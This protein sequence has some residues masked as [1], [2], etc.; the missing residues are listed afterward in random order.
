MSA[1]ER[2]K[3]IVA[4]VRELF[5]QRG[6]D[7]ATTRELARAA[8]VS[9]GLLFK[10]FPTKQ[11][12]YQAMLDS[13]A[14]ELPQDVHRTLDLPPSTQTLIAIVHSLA[15]M[16]LSRH[17]EEVDDVARMY[18]RSLAGDGVFAD[19]LLR[20]PYEDLIPRLEKSM[21]AA[22]VSGDIVD[23]P[24]PRRAR[25]WFTERLIFVLMAELLPRDRDLKF[26][27]SRDTI[28]RDATWFVLRGI[29]LSEEVIRSHFHTGAAPQREV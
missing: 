9:E 22:I 10:H 6:L 18:L 2:Q 5:A 17:P 15:T 11:A 20:K 23:S 19:V 27:A 25:A 14:K 7:G 21:D 3:L 28:V 29:G 24:V 13:I 12:L 4:R 8:G 26:G 1:E 16:F